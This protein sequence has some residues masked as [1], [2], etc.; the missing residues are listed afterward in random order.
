MVEFSLVAPVLLLLVFGIVDF[1]LMLEARVAMSNAARDAG[2]WAA[3][4]PTAW[5]NSQPAPS[6]TIEGQVQTAGGTNAIPND[7]A[8]I[9]ITYLVPGNG[10][11]TPCGHYSAASNSFVPESGFTEGSCVVAGNLIQV[12]VDNQYRLLTPVISSLFPGGSVNLVASATMVEE[13]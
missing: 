2:R 13:Q 3:T 9:T 11:P 1:G 8:H 12:Q 5:T 7:D 4:H 6:N 10:N